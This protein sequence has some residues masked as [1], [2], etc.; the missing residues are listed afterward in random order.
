VEG[1]KG[2]DYKV[3]WAIFRDWWMCSL[4]WLFWS[5]SCFT[6]VMFDTWTVLYTL[7]M[8]N[9]VYINYSSIKKLKGRWDKV[10]C[11]KGWIQL[12]YNIRSLVNVT[13]YPQYNNKQKIFKICLN[14]SRIANQHIKILPF[15]K[16]YFITFHNMTWYEKYYK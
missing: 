6:I 14:I 8:Y 12:W 13:M 7:C 1:S 4:S 2:T 16:Y 10:E 5:S 3:A 15:K 11:W 9:L